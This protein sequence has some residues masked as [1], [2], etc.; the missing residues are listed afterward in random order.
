M[1]A[2]IL[3][4]IQ[5][6]G[7]FVH[8][9]WWIHIQKTMLS[10]ILIT[11]WQ[12]IN[13]LIAISIIIDAFRNSYQS[14][15]ALSKIHNE[16]M[17]TIYWFFYLFIYVYWGCNH[18]GKRAICENQFLTNEKNTLR[19]STKIRYSYPNAMDS[20]DKCWQSFMIPYI[21]YI[22]SRPQRVNDCK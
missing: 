22:L 21:P 11:V 7:K 9:E 6:N 15:M 20:V 2:C 18:Y 10:A 16:S 8:D 4:F 3:A 13:S 5:R 12:C 19:T 1:R 14:L 17:I